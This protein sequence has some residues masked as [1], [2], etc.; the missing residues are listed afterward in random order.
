MGNTEGVI[1]PE[2]WR[3][4][5]ASHQRLVFAMI[6]GLVLVAGGTLTIW[7]KRSAV[8][9][10]T[11]APAVLMVSRPLT[12]DVLEATKALKVTQQETIDQ[13][14]VVQD[15]L[16]AQKLETK[17]MADQIAEITEKLAIV[18]NNLPAASST[19]AALPKSHR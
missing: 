7:G 2:P 8:A 6:A 5:L 4:S 17:K 10:A 13:L 19:S 15:Q 14:Q 18:Q 3:P 1:R 12:D 16:A 11:P 9:S